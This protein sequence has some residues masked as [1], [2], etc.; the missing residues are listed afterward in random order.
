MRTYCP[1]TLSPTATGRKVYTRIPTP[2][3]PPRPPK[4]VTFGYTQAKDDGAQYIP[5]RP[6]KEHECLT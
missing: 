5:R 1:L 3:S 2:S 4:E 6:R